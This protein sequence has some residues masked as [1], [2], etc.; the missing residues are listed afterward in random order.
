MSIP[1]ISPIAGQA[2]V[3]NSRYT[4]LYNNPHFDYL[5][6]MLPK[7]IKELFK[8][9]EVVHQSMPT[10]SNGVRKLINYPITDF[11]FTNDAESIRE[12]TRELLTTLK[13]KSALLEFGSDYY[14]YG[15]VFRTIYFPFKRMLACPRCGQKIA[16]EKANVR[17]RKKQIEHKCPNC[18]VFVVPKVEDTATFDLEKI[19]IVRWDPKQ[20]ELSQNPITGETKYYYAL[21]QKFVKACQRGDITVLRDTPKIFI[22]A[23]LAG[24]NIEM[25]GNFYHAKTSGLAG[26][27]SGWGIPPLMPA[28]KNYMYI[29]VLR[30][31]AE[32]IGMEHIT[33]KTIL[34]PQSSGSTDPC[35]MSSIDRWQREITTAIERWRMDP[36]YVMTA[37]YPTGFTNIGSQGRALTPTEEIKDA[38]ME[39]SL[40]LDIPPGLIMGDTN[41]QNSA[42]GL[43]IL[44]N[45]L[46]PYIEQLTAFINWTVSC[47]NAHTKRA[48]CAVKL[49]PFRLADDM[50]NKQ[51]L[52]QAQGI[53]SRSTLQEALNLEPDKERDRLKQEQLDDHESQREVEKEIQQREQDIANQARAQEQEQATGFPSQYNQQKMIAAAQQQA[54]QMLSIPYEQRRSVLAQLQN[55]DYVMWA[56]VSKQLEMMRDQQ[57]PQGGAMQAG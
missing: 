43:R 11:S 20:I 54:M 39:M 26:F 33:P 3:L 30:R 51:I 6:E 52:M 4:R 13:M 15:N 38:R 42:V 28:L 16:I 36:N 7:D 41:I 46:T 45:Q 34:F 47:I 5:S 53:V 57:Q 25:G 49:V 22:D 17:V 12:K 56:L 37:P 19:R 9:C 1:I 21:P 18:Q 31:A 29:A 23:A 55:E 2:T 8:W 32:A 24:R 10:I 50:M 14:V 44:E 35:I 40:A 27:A 48:Y